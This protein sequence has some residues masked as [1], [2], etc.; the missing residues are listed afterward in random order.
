M[1]GVSPLITVIIPVYN[2]ASYIRRCLDCVTAN[3]YKNLEIICVNDGSRDN[4]AEIL[5][6]IAESDQRIKV[7]NKENAGPSAARND[8]IAASGGDYIMFIDSDDWVHDRYFEIMLDSIVSC[9]ADIVG[10]GYIKT[11]TFDQNFAEYG[12]PQELKSEDPLTSEKMRYVW[13]LIYKAE[14][15]RK[16]SFPEKI[17]I[18]EDTFF[19]F[20]ITACEADEGRE[21]S[22]MSIDAPLYYYYQRNNSALRVN[23]HSTGQLEAAEEYLNYASKMKTE[24]AKAVFI[25]RAFKSALLYRYLEMFSGDYKQKKQE[26]DKLLKRAADMIKGNTVISKKKKDFYIASFKMP[27]VYRAYRLAADR[28]MFEWEKEQKKN[29]KRNSN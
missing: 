11:D 5:E 2:T 24:K 23:T 10:C 8:A 12:I 20:V 3:T 14:L 21:I 1:S 6:D 22:L 4:S 17:R 26:A 27:S 13:G 29:K 16:Y 28:T 25:E 15:V 7:I 18:A 9:G 19:N